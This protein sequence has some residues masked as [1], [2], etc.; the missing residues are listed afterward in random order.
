MIW[1]ISYIIPILLMSI[2]IWTDMKKGQTVAEYL[3][4][5]DGFFDDEELAPI[6]IIVFV[7]IINLL[8]LLISVPILVF[9]L[10]KDIRK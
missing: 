8:T 10:V 1:I 3:D 5:G 2:S 7:P 9:N 6:T 4:E